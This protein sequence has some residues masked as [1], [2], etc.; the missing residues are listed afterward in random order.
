[1]F[2]KSPAPTVA[3]LTVV[4]ADAALE[5]DLR[6]AGA[7]RVD[8]AVFGNVTAEGDMSV[9]PEGR[10]LGEVRAKNLS[11]FGRI[12]GIAHVR[13]HLYVRR[14]GLMRGHARYM[15]LQIE[16]GGVMDG[17]T[18]RTDDVAASSEEDDEDEYAAAE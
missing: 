17:S 1:M 18:S 6:V 4:S 5:G 16:R 15:T 7:L 8:G 10:I 9:G 11:V 13:G 14:G 3:T 2:A 12:D